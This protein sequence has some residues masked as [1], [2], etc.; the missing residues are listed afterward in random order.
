MK[1]YKFTL[2]AALLLFTLGCTS[3]TNLIRSDETSE[4]LSIRTLE[5][6]W[7]AYTIYYT[8]TGGT[9]YGNVALLFD[10]K[11]N[12]RTLVARQWTRIG[13]PKTLL[14][15]INKMDRRG[16][17]PGVYNIVGINGNEYGYLYAAR[18]W[19]ITKVESET[20]MIVYD[21]PSRPSGP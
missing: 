20:T 8:H 21:F 2:A 7:E 14:N 19:L 9:K 15:I 4:R 16:Y 12:G 1:I 17:Q 13:D 6:N 11:D 18:R 10:P 3:D 5:K